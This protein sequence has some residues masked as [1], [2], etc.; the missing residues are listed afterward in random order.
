MIQR[1]DDPY[2]DQ[3]GDG[4]PNLDETIAGTNP[5]D[6]NSFPQGFD[7]PALRA[8]IDIVSFFSPNGDGTNDT[9]Q[10]KE[11]DRYSEQPSM[12]LYSKQAMRY[13]IL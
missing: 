3:D 9:W 1:D 6:P 4:Y 13:L 12:D 7:N 5:L 2:N 10:V 8:S 11:I